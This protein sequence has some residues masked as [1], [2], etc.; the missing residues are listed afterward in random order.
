M[1]RRWKSETRTGPYLQGQSGS[2]Q[3]AISKKSCS[4]QVAITLSL[5]SSCRIKTQ[6]WSSAGEGSGSREDAR[7]PSVVLRRLQALGGASAGPRARADSLSGGA[8][9]EFMLRVRTS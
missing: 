2:N 5:G 4:N 3:S 6:G 7:T 1:E 9:A 8:M